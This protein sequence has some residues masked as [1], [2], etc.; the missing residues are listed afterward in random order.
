MTT[1][2]LRKIRNLPKRG[3]TMYIQEIK[4]KWCYR[5]LFVLLL[6]LLWFLWFVYGKN[7]MKLQSGLSGYAENAFK[8]RRL[9]FNV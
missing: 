4:M 1:G 9:W 3:I 7:I 2:E 5:I 8:V 6:P